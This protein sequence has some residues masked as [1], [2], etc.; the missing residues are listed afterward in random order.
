MSNVF[1][2]IKSIGIVPVIKLENPKDSLL[3][4]KALVEGGLPAAEVTFRTKAA[5]ESIALLK[6]EFPA[7]TTGAGTVLTIEQAEA[8]MA[9]GASFIVTPG[10]NPRIV[11]FCLAKGMPVM[12]GINSPSQVEQGLERGLKL[13]KF[14]PAE[15]SGGV[16]MLKA[17]HGPYADVS[18]VPTGGIDTSNLES[19]LQLPYVAAIG[20]SWMVKEDLIVS[21][22]YDRI[23]ALCAEAV[24]LVRR[25]RGPRLA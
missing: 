4:G 23:T 18:F 16:K 12:P 17:L 19:Y 1:S 20:G 10:F 24:A 25:M 2:I 9:A 7:L 21:G 13:L 22:Q 8:A 3:L 11:D 5:A 14:F 6:K 15:V